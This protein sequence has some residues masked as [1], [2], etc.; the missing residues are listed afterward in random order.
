VLGLKKRID[1][2]EREREA[3]TR[4]S[5]RSDGKEKENGEKDKKREK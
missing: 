3:R 5:P 2:C 1:Y 4:L